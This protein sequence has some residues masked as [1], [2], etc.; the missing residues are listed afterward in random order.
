M[1]A[2]EIVC[3]VEGVLRRRAPGTSL[4]EDRTYAIGFTDGVL[5]A[6]WPEI[7]QVDTYVLPEDADALAAEHPN[8]T[9]G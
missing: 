4:V 8:I 7:V 3:V 2:R 5:D 9:K 6:R 1:I